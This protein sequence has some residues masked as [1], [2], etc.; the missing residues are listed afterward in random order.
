V[1]GT[2]ATAFV[3]TGLAAATAYS[4]E[5]AA[6]NGAGLEGPRSQPAGATTF[7]PGA[8][9][10]VVTTVTA[11]SPIPTGYS[12]L[13][14]GAGFRSEQPVAANG[15]VVFRGLVPQAYSVRLRTV[16]G[17]CRV[18]DPNPRSVTVPFGG[19]VETIFT[20]TCEDDV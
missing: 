4:Y 16:P 14:E 3:D 2:T 1:G 15:R 13:V 9:E 20:V 10:L 12:V 18:T 11:G 5:V 19:S 8:G 17:D 7:G 6:V